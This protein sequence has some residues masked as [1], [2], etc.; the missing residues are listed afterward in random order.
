MNFHTNSLPL[1]PPVQGEK[2]APGGTSLVFPNVTITVAE[3]HLASVITDP[4]APGRT[5][6]ILGFFFV[7][8]V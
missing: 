1:I 3:N 5:H 4:L 6:A 8:G 2:R 7:G